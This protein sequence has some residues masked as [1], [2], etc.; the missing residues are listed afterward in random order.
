MTK[1]LCDSCGFWQVLPS[2]PILCPI[3]D[4]FRHSRS[5][6]G[7]KFYENKFLAKTHQT[8][9]N[10][11]STGVIDFWNEPSIGIGPKGHLVSL[12][13]GNFLFDLVPWFSFEALQK[14]RELGGVR[15]VSASHPHAYGALWQIQDAFRPEVFIQRLDLSWT[16]SF[17]VTWPFDEELQ[18]VQEVKLIHSG[19][20]F[21]GHT[22][23]YYPEAKT[24]FLG[25]MIKLHFEHNSLCALSS[26]KAFNR[27]IPTTHAEIK[28]YRNILSALVFDRVYTTFDCAPLSNAD[29][30]RFFDFMSDQRPSCRPHALE[31]FLS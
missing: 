11:S 14:I 9:W 20:H 23:L 3:C 2:Q 24:V 26:H 13:E 22:I 7:L 16:S 17:R 31:E 5:E 10:Q 18:S 4:D 1:F 30:L 27:Q 19:G 15:W 21:D 8:W 25:D 29:V 12:R 28:H 6:A